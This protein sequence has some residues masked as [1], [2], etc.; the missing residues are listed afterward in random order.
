MTP[1]LFK[2]QD[3]FRK[4][5]E[6]HGT[7]DRELWVAFYKKASGKTAMSYA[8]AVDAALCFGWIDGIKRRL[9]DHRYMHRFTPRTARSTWSAINLR[10]IKQLIAAGVVAEPGRR[11]YETRDPKRA[12]LY[13]FEN[14]HAVLDD[15]LMERFQANRQAFAFFE[16][17]PAGYRRLTT[18][19]ITT[20]KKAE[21]RLRRLDQLVAASAEGKRLPWT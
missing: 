4:W 7:R 9:D 2:T 20:A 1:K 18:F 3:A 17:Q 13:S 16:A 10:R 19:W 12:G 15:V 8:E 6:A 21:T 11:A 14:P 5:L